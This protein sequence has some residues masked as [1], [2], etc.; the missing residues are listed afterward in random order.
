[1]LQKRSRDG[2]PV[3]NSTRKMQRALLQ[4]DV[5]VHW[6][7]LSRDLRA[8]GARY[9]FRPKTADLTAAHKEKR[10]SPL[11]SKELTKIIVT[12]ESLFDCAGA[13]GSRRAARRIP[14]RP[15]GRRGPTCGGR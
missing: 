9:L 13:N 12:D 4:E 2:S 6:S 10:F 8:V 11:R 3:F 1:M 7:T 15:S 14:K 5:G